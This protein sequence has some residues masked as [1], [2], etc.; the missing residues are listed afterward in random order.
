MTSSKKIE[1]LL[2]NVWY[3][4]AIDLFLSAIKRNRKGRKIIIQCIVGDRPLI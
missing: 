1:H 3:S 2:V 4:E